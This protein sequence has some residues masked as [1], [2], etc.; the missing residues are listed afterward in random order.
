MDR[1]EFLKRLGMLT[2]GASLIGVD[3]AAMTGEATAA[4]ATPPKETKGGNQTH[5]DLDFAVRPLKAATNRAVTAII[6]GAGSRGTTYGRYALQFPDTMKIVGVADTN[7]FRKKRTAKAHSIAAQN[8]FDDWSEVFAREKFA[9]AV[10][11]ATPDNLHY[12]PCMKALAMGY[13]VLLEKPAAQTEKECK[14]ILAQAKKYNR[15]VA[16]CHVL[17]YAPYFIAM[18]EAVRSGLIGDLVSIQH[19]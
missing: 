4:T 5:P 2:V 1:K 17:R 3:M 7:N 12:E 13:D 18:R 11:I 6:I 15:I 8:C 14:D 19:M 9:D 10:I 16:I